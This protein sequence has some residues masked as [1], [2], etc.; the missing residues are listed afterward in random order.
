M[1]SPAPNPDRRVLKAQRVAAEL[2][3]Y[4]ERRAATRAEFDLGTRDA[5]ADALADLACLVRDIIE[6]EPANG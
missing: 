2:E 5:F 6:R 3:R 1:P 4:A